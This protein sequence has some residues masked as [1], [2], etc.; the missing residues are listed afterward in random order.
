MSDQA[1][2]Q[3]AR[4]AK[5]H[6][7]AILPPGLELAGIGISLVDGRTAVKVNLGSAPAKELDL[8]KTVDGVPV[9]YEV[10]GKIRARF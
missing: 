7:R 3:R 4:D 5:V 2:Y 6:L 9:I 1:G 8:P 10:V